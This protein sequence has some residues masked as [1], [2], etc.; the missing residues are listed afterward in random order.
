VQLAL[1]KQ[2][3]VIYVADTDLMLTREHKL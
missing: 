2:R 3:S 1:N